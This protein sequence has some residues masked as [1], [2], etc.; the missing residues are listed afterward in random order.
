MNLQRAH[1]KSLI[2][3]T[4]VL[5][6][7]STFP[8]SHTASTYYISRHVVLR[9]PGKMAASDNEYSPERH[10]SPPSISI[11]TSAVETFTTSFAETLSRTSSRLSSESEN[12]E[13][14][15]SMYSYASTWS[16][17]Y[18]MSDL[19]GA[20]R[21]LGNIYSRAGSSLEKGLGTIAYH[22]WIRRYAREIVKLHYGTYRVF[23]NRQMR[24]RRRA[25]KFLLICARLDDTKIQAKA[26]EKIVQCFVEF[27]SEARSTFGSV[28]ESRGVINDIATSSWRRQGIKYD[29]G[30]TYW[31][32]LVS[33]CLLSAPNRFIE[34]ASGFKP[35]RAQTVSFS[36]FV[37]LLMS[38]GDTT[39]LLL[40][41][42]IIDSHWNREGL[43]DFI[44]ERGFGDS[45]VLALISGFIAHWEFRFRK[46]MQPSA[47]SSCA[48]SVLL[49]DR[50][51]NAM[52]KSLRVCEQETLDHILENDIQ[53]ELWADVFRIHFSIRR[54]SG[55]WTNFNRSL[56]RMTWKDVCRHYLPKAEQAELCKGLSRLED[57]H[58]E[59]MFLRL[60]PDEMYLYY[61]A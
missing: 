49:S 26:F 38:C 58:G 43:E 36:R 44:S 13:D 55:C 17:N 24:R 34:E 29:D 21:I 15:A 46:S 18:T 59:T 54:D 9:T 5:S 41:N 19:V 22:A 30:W 40:A 32:K 35:A 31:Y 57:I 25:C 12:Q 23:E 2:I 60:L 39:D 45:A 7:L 11:S 56:P 20:G 28:F 4:F 47:V 52:F 1:S 53:T 14:N 61:D 8:W 51:V 3:D 48:A 50:V 33:R 42:Q 27:P 10:N 37:K 6:R 16:T